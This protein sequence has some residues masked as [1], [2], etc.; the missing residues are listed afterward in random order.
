[1]SLIGTLSGGISSA[2]DM[3][4]GRSQVGKLNEQGVALQGKINQN[5]ADYQ[6][7]INKNRLLNAQVEGV[8]ANNAAIRE[9]T[10]LNSFQTIMM[11][12]TASISQDVNKQFSGQEGRQNELITI[13]VIGGLLIIGFLVYQNFGKNEK[14]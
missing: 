1:M 8:E 4:F 5:E 7:Q 10:A 12:P 11:T 2:F 14:K 9:A 6:N 3:A 13:A